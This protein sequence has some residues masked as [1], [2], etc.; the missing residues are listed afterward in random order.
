[1]YADKYYIRRFLRGRQHDIPK[2]K[3]MYSDHLAWRKE[4]GVD[5]IMTTFDFTERDSFLTLYPQGYHKTDKLVRSNMYTNLIYEISARLF[6]PF[7]GLTN[8]Q[9]ADVQIGLLVSSNVIPS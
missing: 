4:N 3:A 1:M 2:A 6:A 8:I 7:L 5:D 9:P